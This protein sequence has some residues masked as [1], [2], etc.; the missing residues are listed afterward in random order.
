M[1]LHYSPAEGLPGCN[2]AN[3]V[4][5]CHTVLLGSTSVLVEHCLLFLTA[6]Y[7]YLNNSKEYAGHLLR[8]NDCLGGGSSSKGNS[9]PVNPNSSLKAAYKGLYTSVTLCR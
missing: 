5:F 7:L 3:F 6:K 4:L 2:K 9:G 1:K 8:I